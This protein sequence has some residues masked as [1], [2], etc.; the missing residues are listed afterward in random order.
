MDQCENDL[1]PTFYSLEK[2]ISTYL[3]R[4][5][6]Y[7]KETPPEI[8][9]LDFL[10]NEINICKKLQSELVKPVYNFHYGGQVGYESFTKLLSSRINKRLILLAEK[11]NDISKKISNINILPERKDLIQHKKDSSKT[12]ELIIERFEIMDSKGWNYAFRSEKDF[13]SYVDLLSNFFEFQSYKL[14]K[15]KIILKKSTKSKVA[16]TLG[17][18]HKELSEKRLSEDFKFLELVSILNHFS[19]LSDKDI[20]KA[21]SK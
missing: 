12:M 2:Y 17:E 1:L 3:S 18:I 21:L 9:E 6:D 8:E 4:L 11:Y 5:K 16:I 13:L 19:D 15:E 7:L 20:A 14:P 10:E